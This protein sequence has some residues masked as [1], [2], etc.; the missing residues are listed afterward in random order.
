MLFL[1]DLRSYCLALPATT[2]SLPFDE[3][4]LVFKVANKIFVITN[5]D[6]Y[7]S[8]S[9]KCDPDTAQSLRQQH[10]DTVTAGYH[11]NKR[12]WN[13]ISIDGTLTPPELLRWVRHSYDLVC[14]TLPKAQQAI[15]HNL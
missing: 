5:I 9:L 13:T 10:P 11:L 6:N 3:N 1:D 2:E 15:I 7:T 4:T 8:I 14:A 12:H